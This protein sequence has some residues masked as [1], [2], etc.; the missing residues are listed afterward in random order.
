MNSKDKLHI[1]LVNIEYPKE[2]SIGGISTY[3]KLLAD[4]LIRKGHKVTVISASFSENQDY[5]EDGIHVIMIKAEFPFRSLKGY[6]K[7]REEVNRILNSIVDKDKIDVIETPEL[8]ADTILYQRNRKIPIVVKLHTSYKIWKEY[9]DDINHF[10]DDINNQILLYEDELLKNADKIIICSDLLRNMMKD[11]YDFIDID[12]ISVVPNPVDVSS[13]KPLRNA[14]KSKIVLFCGSIE[15]RKGVYVL[16]KA[17]PLVLKEYDDIIFRFIGN[18]EN[19]DVDGICAKDEIY[20]MIPKKYHKNIEFLGIIDNKKLN[21]Y[22]NEAYCG[23]VGSLFD[24]F[25]YVALEEILSELPLIASSNTGVKEMITNKESGLLY[26]PNDYKELSKLILFLLKNPYV[27]KKMGKK[28]RKEIIDK[29][30]PEYIVDKNIEIYKGVI[31][32]FKRNK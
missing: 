3:Q 13:F 1:C 17:I 4:T 29:Y 28:A 6:I 32:E 30:N 5:Y 9:N 26:E 11:Y 16:A 8:S 20:K 31:S 18:Y 12:K 10:S 15:K 25:P 2:T 24:N 19:M 14:H 21:K 27:A 7:Y 23:I 22:Y